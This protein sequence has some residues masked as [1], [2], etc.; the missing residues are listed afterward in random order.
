MLW[1][2]NGER[3][4]YYSEQRDARALCT[5]QLVIVTCARASAGTPIVGMPYASSVLDEP[6]ELFG[7][8]R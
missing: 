7:R 4:G 2:F 8:M 5:R 6:R 1:D 3:V